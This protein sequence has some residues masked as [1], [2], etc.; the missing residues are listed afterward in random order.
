MC[1]LSGED[2]G[3][4]T[5]TIK[6]VKTTPY[7]RCPRIPGALDT[8]QPPSLHSHHFPGHQGR[9]RKRGTASREEMMDK[10]GY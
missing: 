7:P 1:G 3:R 6:V 8:E 9:E 10:E 2:G 4:L 5:W